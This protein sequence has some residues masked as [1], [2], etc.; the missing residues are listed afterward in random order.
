MARR[1]GIEVIRAVHPFAELIDGR[2]CI[3]RQ[4]H[5][6]RGDAEAVRCSL[7]LTNSTCSIEYR[8][9]FQGQVG[10]SKTRL[11]L[12]TFHERFARDSCPPRVR[13]SFGRDCTHRRPLVCGIGGEIYCLLAARM[14]WNSTTKLFRNYVTGFLFRCRCKNPGERQ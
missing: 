3:G 2:V 14:S 1:A 12:C 11:L 4:I 10:N 8:D 6:S 5:K 13:D 7:K 9:D